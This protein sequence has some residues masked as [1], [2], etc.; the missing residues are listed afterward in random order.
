MRELKYLKLFE[1]FESIKLT[2]TLGYVDS[3]SREELIDKLKIICSSI[4]FPISQ[5]TDDYFKYLPLR[6]IN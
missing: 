2:K 6:K 3:K 4:D 5:L 1:A